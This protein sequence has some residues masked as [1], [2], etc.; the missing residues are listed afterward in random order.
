M[1]DLRKPMF[2]LPCISSCASKWSTQK[3]ILIGPNLSQE[4]PCTNMLA[5][6][7]LSIRSNRCF[8]QGYDKERLDSLTH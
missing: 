3:R 1:V 5:V 2:D 8:L 6:D 7:T 4:N